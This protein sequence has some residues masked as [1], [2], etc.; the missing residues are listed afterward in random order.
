MKLWTGVV[1]DQV[2]ESRDFYVRLFACEVVFDS[3]WFVLLELGGGELGFMKPGLEAQHPLF[4]TPLAGGAGIWVTI[5]VDDVDA[6]YA[7]LYGLGVEAV[8]PPRDE[9]WGDRH[10]AVI[11]P[12]GIAVDVVQRAAPGEPG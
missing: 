1:T 11:D 9:P 4:R 2:T 10:F 8:F 6:T 3:D 5:D 12:G 7:R